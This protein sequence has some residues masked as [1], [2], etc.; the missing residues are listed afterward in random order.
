MYEFC[1]WNKTVETHLMSLLNLK[2]KFTKEN[3]PRGNK[4]RKANLAQRSQSRTHGHY[5]YY[6]EN[7]CQ[8]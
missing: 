2:K 7:A 3:A 6:L 4:V 1:I 8:I 5:Y